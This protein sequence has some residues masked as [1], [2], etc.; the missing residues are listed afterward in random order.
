MTAHSFA[1]KRP[2]VV[3]IATLRPQAPVENC[4]SLSQIA[5]AAPT[6]LEFLRDGEYP[7]GTNFSRRTKLEEH[8]PPCAVEICT[9][10]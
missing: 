4:S 7:A 3:D 5:C 8:F 1:T 2:I 10:E 9:S 6:I